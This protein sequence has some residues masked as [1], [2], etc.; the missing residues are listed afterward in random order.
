MVL[1]RKSYDASLARTTGLARSTL[2]IDRCDG[3]WGL[4]VAG[5]LA[6][7]VKRGYGY[8]QANSDVPEGVH[9]WFPSRVRGFAETIPFGSVAVNEFDARR[10]SFR[11]R[12]LPQGSSF[13]FD[14]RAFLSPGQDF[15]PSALLRVLSGLLAQGL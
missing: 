7:T 8:K 14:G 11:L 9:G 10:P 5:A 6:K 12:C 4:S 3:R 1:F 2:A 13:P 15:F